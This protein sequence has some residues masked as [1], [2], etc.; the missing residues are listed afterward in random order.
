MKIDQEVNSVIR[1]NLKLVITAKGESMATIAK[2]MG[3][4]YSMFFKRMTSE[5]SQALDIAFV[6]AVCNILDVKISDV[7]P[8]L[9]C[10][11]KKSTKITIELKG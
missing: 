7:L 11:P 2:K 5:Y 3:M 6:I 9:P 8:N 4:G 1:T 10:N